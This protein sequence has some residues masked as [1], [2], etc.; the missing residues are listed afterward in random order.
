MTLT[1]FWQRTLAF[2]G[3][4]VALIACSTG[5]QITTVE[6]L[7]ESADAPYQNVLVIA[8]LSSFDSRRYLE[9]EIVNQLSELGT[10]AVASTSMMDSRTPMVRQTFVAMVDEINADAVLATHLVSLQATGEMKDM[11]PET[12]YNIRPTYY[13]NVWSVEY[14][15][16]VEPQALELTNTLVLSTQ[17]YSVSARDAVWAIELKS[18]IVQKF[19]NMRD[20]SIYVDEAKA[21]ATQMSKD[22]LIVR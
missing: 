5:P 7:S 4:A 10:K 11:R 17:L 12:T 13:Y 18:K 6:E 2:F 14:T 19:D 21:I 3:T 20:Y 15:E 16:Y 1:I 8:L 9:T 22:G